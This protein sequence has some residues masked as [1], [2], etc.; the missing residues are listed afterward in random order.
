MNKKITSIEKAISI[1]GGQT[2]LAQKVGVTQGAVWKW[3]NG[4]KKVS[5][6]NVVAIVSATNGEVK[7]HEIRPDLPDLFPHPKGKSHVPDT[8]H[9]DA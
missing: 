6:V 2:H 8:Q 7:A 4:I 1:A 3:L 5:P 9:T